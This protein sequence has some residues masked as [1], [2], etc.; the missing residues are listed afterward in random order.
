MHANRGPPLGEEK[1]ASFQMKSSPGKVETQPTEHWHRFQAQRRWV[2]QFHRPV[3]LRNV[4]KRA[5]CLG[6]SSH[7]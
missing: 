6:L 1:K 3:T 7:V 2:F 4:T 5:D